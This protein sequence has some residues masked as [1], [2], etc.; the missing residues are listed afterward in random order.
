[1]KL[2]F[3]SIN[4]AKIQYY[5]KLCKFKMN[6]R[7]FLYYNAIYGTQRGVSSDTPL[8]NIIFCIC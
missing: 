1:M 7:I 5:F 2:S 3:V 8:C 4:D 6:I